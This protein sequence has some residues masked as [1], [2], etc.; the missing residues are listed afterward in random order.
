MSANV[1]K[2]LQREMKRVKSLSLL[3]LSMISLLCS[4]PQPIAADTNISAHP[5]VEWGQGDVSN[6]PGKS[7]CGD[8]NNVCPPRTKPN[9]AVSSTL[10]SI[11]LLNGAFT[12]QY[13][14]T[15]TNKTD[16][17]ATNISIQDTVTFT[18]N[19]VTN[20]NAQILYSS[21]PVIITNNVLSFPTIPSIDAKSGF[22]FIFTLTATLSPGTT[23]N[24]NQDFVVSYEQKCHHK[25]SCLSITNSTIEEQCQ[26]TPLVL[27]NTVPTVI[28]QPGN[29][30]VTNSPSMQ[31][32]G[33]TFAN[34][35][36]CIIINSSDVHL[37]LC[38]QV[39]TGSGN[40][41]APL[42]PAPTIPG[43]IQNDTRVD[44][45]V[46]IRI[47]GTATNILD[48]IT[49]TNG[50]L[51]YYSYAG[52]YATFV[53]NLQLTNLMLE[54]NS[55]VTTGA[56]GAALNLFDCSALF[57]DGIHCANNRFVDCKIVNNSRIGQNSTVKNLYSKGLRGASVG[58]FFNPAWLAIP[59]YVQYGGT[60]Y[61]LSVQGVASPVTQANIVLENIN[62]TDL[63]S[64][65]QAFGIFVQQSANTVVIRN[66]NI[67]DMGQMFSDLTIFT[68]GSLSPAYELRGYAIER[69]LGSPSMNA[70]LENCTAQDLFMNYSLIPNTPGSG[71]CIGFNTE[72]AQQHVVRNCIARNI[73]T[74]GKVRSLTP[75]ANGELIVD[76]PAIGFGLQ[77]EP[78]TAGLM[79]YELI[80]CSAQTITAGTSASTNGPANA[81]G[82]CVY[83]TEGSQLVITG[84]TSGLFA[85]CT[86]QDVTGASTSAGF[87]INIGDFGLG[88]PPSKT[89]L[90]PIV[91]ENCVA[92]QDRVHSPTA[93]SNGFLTIAHANNIVFRGCT[94]IGHTLNGFELDGY[95]IDDATGNAKY[96]LDNCIANGNSCYGFHLAH[97]LKQAEVINCK[98]TNN[99]S[100]G[101]NAEGR[102]LVFRN[103]A[104]DLNLGQ[105]F[106]FNQ[107][108]PF[109][110]NV[111]TDTTNVGMANL[112]VYGGAYT[113]SYVPG[114][115]ALPGFYQYFEIIPTNTAAP[116][117]PS[118]TINGVTVNNGDI[119]LIKD[120]IGTDQNTGAT[121]NG[122]YQA[123]MYGGVVVSGMTVPVWQL[124]RVDPWRAPYTIPMGTK[125]LVAN[126]NALGTP[127]NLTPAPVMYTIL[128]PLG[129]VVDTDAPTFAATTAVAPDNSSI[130]VDNCKAALNA[131]NGLH[132]YA[133]DVTVRETVAD[134]NGGYGFL[135]DSV[136]GA[137][138]YANL[139][140][141]NKAFNNDVGNYKFDY[142]GH[143]GVLL[144]GSISGVFS[145]GLVWP[146]ANESI[147][148]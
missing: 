32:T 131:S 79:N 55:H 27:S 82:F 113:V 54:N 31:I 84:S 11:E 50:K 94:A 66:C 88:V 19:V 96:I 109:F 116:L 110:A 147:T 36:A 104:S 38:G 2:I 115:V 25:R 132:N 148:P 142:S 5:K 92:E 135:D 58:G 99:G 46:G 24:V 37:D 33:A 67:T 125:V 90:G 53:D 49:I 57:V 51:Q 128:N 119:V 47:P 28:S 117:P 107:Y 75:S 83:D 40:K 80:G 137:T 48:N 86:A 3:S 144:T 26:I 18:D 1:F 85:N 30:I 17:N 63:K 122:V 62:I 68:G 81:Y 21:S 41:T 124:I 106:F 52:I 129:V 13:L 34:P 133:K 14:I 44:V 10:Q 74:P 23:A 108:Y 114:T 72:R 39:L 140:T 97:S 61:G 87:T 29:Y 134:R 56:G 127:P 43:G 126:S 121:R 16:C 100:D 143:A 6:D 78:D 123:Y 35:N 141:R 4:I 91:F 15:L 73:S 45:S 89:T 120:L 103:T 76:A 9:L 138:L 102:D 69:G 139:Y 20:L 59:S 64:G 7:I 8:A 130:V 12:A 118:L 111:A 70:L 71:G 95:A 42:S 105:G 146:Q 77:L 101:I 22:S 98:S 65:S 93:L 136:G 112:G 60:S 145:T